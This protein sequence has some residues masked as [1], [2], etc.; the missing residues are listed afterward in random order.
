MADE[1]RTLLMA[2]VSHDLRTPL[3]RIRLATEMMGEEDGYLASRSIKTSKGVTP[4]SNSLLTICVPVRK[5]QWRWPDLNSVLGEV[6]AAESGY[7]GVRLT[8][9]APGREHRCAALN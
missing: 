8:L 6:I 9:R 2:G 1:G 7:E 3:T 4:L 5:C